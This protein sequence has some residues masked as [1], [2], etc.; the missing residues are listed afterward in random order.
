MERSQLAGVGHLADHRMRE[1]PAA[2]HAEDVFEALRPHDGDHP[3]LALGDHDLP[4]L[5][6]RLAERDLVEVDVDARAVPRHLG[7]RGS[8]PGR[9]A[10]L[11]RLHETALDELQ[12][13]LD[14]L[15]ARERISD[16]NGRPL[17]R[18]F[19]AKLLA[20]EDTGAA[21]PVPAGRRAVEDQQSAGQRCLR[22]GE[23]LDG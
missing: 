18:V 11:Q 16:L 1:L 8:E 23:P 10:V 5:H 14:Q 19:L 20:G 13:R 15:L 17:V 2:A 21:D 4:G 7:Q 3:L 6:L 9:A 12:A 22:A